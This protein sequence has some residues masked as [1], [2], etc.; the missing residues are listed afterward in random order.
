M[1]I[2]IANDHAAVSMKDVISEYLKTLGIDVINLGTNDDKSVD[3]PKYAEK[4]CKEV[5]SKNVDLGILICGTGLGMCIA[6][7]KI[8]GIRAVS[9]ENAFSASMAREHNDANVLCIGARVV[10][11]EIAKNIVK[12]FIDS[13]FMGD[14]HKRRVDQI[15]ELEEKGHISD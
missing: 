12:E 6:A 1:K 11:I 7:N 14:R 9:V 10:G 15:I 5:I 8:K 13:K 3:Y 4:V 2:A